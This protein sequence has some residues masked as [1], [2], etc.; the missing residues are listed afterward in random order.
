MNRTQR[1]A[2]LIGTLLGDASFSGKVKK[3]IL[4]GHCE[5]QK[6]YGEWKLKLIGKWFNVKTKS[7]IAKGTTSPNNFRTK[8]Y[9]FWTGS[10][11]RFT[12]LFKRMVINNK[13]NITNYSLKYFTEISLAVLFM[14]DGRKETYKGKI[15]TF[16][17]SLGGFSI[18]E[19]TKLSLHIE[20]KF[21]IRTKMY[22]EHR[23]YPCLKITGKENKE[24]FVKLIKPYI[25]PS[26]LYKI[27]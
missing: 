16:K 2:F 9:R 8:F 17:F 23:K 3:H 1:R 19:V 11:H 15:K 22:L 21:N 27:Q 18:N 14:D 7:C 4:F 13:K 5:K 25:H 6:E 24:N 26:M 12:A 20:Q 10:D